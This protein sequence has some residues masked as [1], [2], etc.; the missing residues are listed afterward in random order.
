MSDILRIVIP[1]EMRGKGRPRFTT[2][3]GFA[4]AFTDSKTVNMEAWVRACAVDA[5]AFAAGYP[6][7]LRMEMVAAVPKSWTK[8]NRARALAGDMLPTGKPD[9]DN[10]LKLVCDA[11][12]GIAWQDDKQIVSV[13]ATKRYGETAETILE[14]WPA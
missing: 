8:G 10:C 11:L 4:R 5:G 2:R 14:V 9:L 13:D 6:L 12:N 7:K 1:G 3:G